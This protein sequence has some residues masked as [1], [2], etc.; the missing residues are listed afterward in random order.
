MSSHSTAS[1][2]AAGKG[3]GQ[4]FHLLFGKLGLTQENTGRIAAGIGQA[5]HIAPRNRIVIVGDEHDGNRPAR[6]HKRLQRR[7][8]AQGDKHIRVGAGHFSRLRGECGQILI[9]R[10]LIDD[11]I[12]A[13]AETGFL[14]FVQERPIG[15]SHDGI[16]GADEHADASRLARL[17]RARG[18]RRQRRRTAE[19]RD[20]FAPPHSITLSAR[21]T[22]PAGIS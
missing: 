1:R 14:Q 15:R 22:R 3:L 10:S 5:L 11:Q 20:E 17:L 13:L 7:L 4:Q 18:E 8:R 21:R 2:V 16:A 12:L 19:Q 6:P 9:R